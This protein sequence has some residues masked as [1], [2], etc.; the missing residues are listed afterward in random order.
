PGPGP[1]A[2]DAGGGLPPAHRPGAAGMIGAVARNRLWNLRH[3]RAAMVLSFVVPLV[4]FSIFAAIF[5]RESNRATTPHITLA[6]ADEDASVRSR[7]FL[8]A[9]RA[10]PALS[11][12]TAP[13][14]LAVSRSGSGSSAPTFTAASAEAAVRAGDLAVA[15]IIPR[16]FGSQ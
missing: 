13:K 8:A 6:V 10:E 7:G 11:V 4:F 3:D 16:G 15:L 1:E 9:L 5:G 12:I 2:L 14:T